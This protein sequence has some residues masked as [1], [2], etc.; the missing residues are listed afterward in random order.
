MDLIDITWFQ[1][2]LDWLI[3]LAPD[4]DIQI[5]ARILLWSVVAYMLVIIY[6]KATK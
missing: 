4:G 2:K 1:T 3:S 6:K 5:V